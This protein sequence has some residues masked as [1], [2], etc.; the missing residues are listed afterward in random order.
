MN[1]IKTINKAFTSAQDRNWDIIYWAIDLHG[2]ISSS[3]YS[4][5]DLSINYNKYAKIMLQFLSKNKNFKLMLYTCSYKDNVEKIL[6]LFKK[7][8]I[9]FDYVNKNPEVENTTYGDYTEKPYFNIL[10]DD[11]AGFEPEADWEEMFYYFKDKLFD[12][13]NFP[14]TDVEFLEEMYKKETNEDT[15]STPPVNGPSFTIPVPT[16]EQIKD[17]ISQNYGNKQ[18]K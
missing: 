5:D 11:K 15:N 18:K 3:N 6:E 7:D 17:I 13:G 4:N 9:V 2:T 8:D 1:I 10:L 12:S 16:K 14:I